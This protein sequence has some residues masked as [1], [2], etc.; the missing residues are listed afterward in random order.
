MWLLVFSFSFPAAFTFV[1]ARR[2]NR[3]DEYKNRPM[4]LVALKRLQLLPRVALSLTHSHALRTNACKC[5]ERYQ[6]SSI[7]QWELYLRLFLSIQVFSVCYGVLNTRDESGQFV[8]QHSMSW[9]S[10]QKVT[11]GHWWKWWCYL[12]ARRTWLPINGL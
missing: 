5:E 3:Y 2:R 7:S 1:M 10:G 9:K 12:R 4:S 8:A 11:W 6:K